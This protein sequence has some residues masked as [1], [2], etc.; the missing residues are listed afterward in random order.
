M[1]QV[2]KRNN[3]S[4]YALLPSAWRREHGI[5]EGSEIRLLETEDGKLV[6]SAEER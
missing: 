2:V 4:F 5:E 6:I 3:N 1:K